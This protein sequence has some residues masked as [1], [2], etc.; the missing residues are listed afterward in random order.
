MLGDVVVAK[1]MALLSG[2]SETDLRELGYVHN[3]TMA[4]LLLTG[5]RRRYAILVGF[6]TNG[7]SVCLHGHETYIA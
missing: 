5:Q 6:S 7:R 2:Q 4:S 1:F 3:S